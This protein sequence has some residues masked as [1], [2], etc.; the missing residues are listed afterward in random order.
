MQ[1]RLISGPKRSGCLI[2]ASKLSH[3]AVGVSRGNLPSDSISCSDTET[4]HADWD[5][6]T[7]KKLAPVV[8]FHSVHSEFPFQ[9]KNSITTK[10]FD[11]VVYTVS[12]V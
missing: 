4:G 7:L 1:K 9:F 2:L 11:H 5:R 12:E 3:A 10:Q 8:D 6:V